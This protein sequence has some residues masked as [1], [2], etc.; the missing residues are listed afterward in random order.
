MVSLCRY[1]RRPA[2]LTTALLDEVCNTYFLADAQ[3]LGT[4]AR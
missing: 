4:Q 1:H 3:N 2:E